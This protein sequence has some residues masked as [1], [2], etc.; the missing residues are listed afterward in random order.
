MN[1]KFI[2]KQIGLT[3]NETEIYLVALEYGWQPASIIAKRA[4]INRATTYS[5]LKTLI[6]KGL[7][8]QVKKAQGIYFHA[9][10]PESLLEYLEKKKENIEKNKEILKYHIESIKSKKIK[11]NTNPQVTFYEE[12]EGIKQIHEDILKTS[13]NKTIYSII[14]QN[15]EEDFLNFLFFDFIKRRIENNIFIEVI[16][17]ESKIGE[18]IQ[19]NDKNS[20]RTTKIISNGNCIFESEITIY[21]EKIALISYK[22]EEM[23]GII[24]ESPSISKTMKEIFKLTW[25]S[26]SS[27][28]PSQKELFY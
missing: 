25:N 17:Q 7:V 10:D 18:K 5:V 14:P 11:S 21:G 27:F 3:T 19:Y 28:L 15:M 16:A 8:E 22:K 13:K 26:D 23:I 2:L 12:L 4:R 6:Q 20:L 1:T 24:V 9:K